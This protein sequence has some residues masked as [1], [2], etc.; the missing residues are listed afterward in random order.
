M[1]KIPMAAGKVTELTGDEVVSMNMWGFT[2]RI[3]PELQEQFKKFLELNSSNLKAEFFIP[4]VVN[5]LVS[6]GQA[7]VKVLPSNDS[8]FGITYREDHPRVV[9]S[10]NHLIHDGYYPERLW[11]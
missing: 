5:E 1:L 4:S 8:W 6:A 10:I 3:F 2:P 7:R 9:A 11:S